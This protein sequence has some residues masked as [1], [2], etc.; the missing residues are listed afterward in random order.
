MLRRPGRGFTLIELLLVIGIVAIL[1]SIVIVAI[2]PTR[3]LAQA[4][5]AQRHSD[6]RTILDAV[7][8]NQIAGGTAI[9]GIQTTLRMLGTAASGCAVACGQG[10]P[11]TSQI[12]LY[13]LS[14]TTIDQ[15]N[16]TANNGSS[17]QVWSQSWLAYNKRGLV[18]FDLSGI[19]AG[20]TINSATLT[21]READTQGTTR[22]V[23]VH[24]MTTDWTEAAN[25]LTAN[26][27]A[28]W[29]AN[30]GD[31]AGSATATASVVWSGLFDTDS[32]NVAADVQAFVNGSAQNYGW[33]LKDASEGSSAQYRWQFATRETADD[34]S[35]TVNYTAGAETTA[36]ACL[37][38]SSALVGDILAGI[39]E[40]PST[41]DASKTF[42]AIRK[43]SASE[44]ILVRACSAELGEN[45]ELEQ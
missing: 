28:S 20:A 42:Y 30:G 3:Q 37:D 40:D 7:R 41:G 4:R 33:L 18:K 13:A 26:G 2:N 34:P 9:G 12:T 39:P 44:R 1:A 6:V 45:I 32:W 38:L 5:N 22:T 10:T 8:Q 21:L 24:R 23:A 16:T 11:T 43:S 14:D 31:F 35:L 29:G 27:S 25:W 36:D 19:P 15:G 17:S